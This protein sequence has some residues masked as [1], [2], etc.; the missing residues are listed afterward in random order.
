MNSDKTVYL[1]DY[2]KPDYLIPN[3]E[4]DF[5]ILSDRVL[6]SNT[7]TVIKNHSGN[8]PVKLNGVNL[9]LEK[10]ELDG[11]VLTLDQYS[12]EDDLL[13]IFTGLDRFILH[14]V[15]SINPFNNLSLEGFY[16]SGN[17]LCTQ[18]EPE[19]FR[20]I[21]YFIDRPDVMS[22]YKTKIT[23]DK[24]NFP[25]LL[26]NGNKISSGDLS[27][28]RHFVQWED[29]FPK[30]SYLFALV[31]GDLDVAED[32]FTTMSGRKISLSIFVDKGKLDRVG[33]A[34]ESLKKA[35]KW[36]EDRFGLECDLDNYMIVSVDSFNAGAMENKGL[37]IFN[38]KYTLGNP[39]TATDSALRGIEAVIAHEYF[40]NWTG[41]RITCRDWFQLT[42]KEGLTVF[43]DHEFSADMINEAVYRIGSVR[44]LRAAQ[45]PEDS[46]PLAHPIRPASYIE[47][48]NF[49]TSTVYEKGQEVIRMIQTFIGKDMF[50]KGID[51]YF[52]L[53][54]GQAVTTDEFINA[55]EI[56]SGRDFTQFRNWYSQEG[57][58]VCMASSL[59]DKEKK[60]YKL[61]ICQ[62]KAPN[63]KDIQ[64]PFCFPFILALLD[65]DGNPFSLSV[66]NETEVTLDIHKPS[67]TFIFD[68]INEKPVPSLLRNFSAPVILNYD[69]SIE[70]LIFLFKY[71]NDSFNRYEAGQRIAYYALESLMDSIIKK[72]KLNVA[73]DVLDAY[74]SVLI[75]EKLNPELRSMMMTLP[76]LSSTLEKMSTYNVDLAFAAREFLLK[77]L[78]LKTEKNLLSIY[79]KFAI[80]KYSSENKYIARRCLKNTC[81]SILSV[82][83]GRY[84][85]YAYKQYTVSKNMTDIVTALN[86]LNNS[87]DLKLRESVLDDFYKKWNTDPVVIN[88]WFTI[89]A[90]TKSGNILK[91][92]DDLSK[93][94][95]FDIKN[96]NKVMSLYGGFTANLKNF[97]DISGNGYKLL[98]DKIIEID[99]FNPHLAA[100]LAKSFKKY[101]E[102]DDK[103]KELM[104]LQLLRITTTNSC[105]KGLSEI[106][107]MI[108]KSN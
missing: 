43:R 72:E 74:E 6:V 8:N 5:N 56:A 17:I 26:S 60:Q 61:T 50:N 23:A 59:Y 16:K 79:K 67:E 39:E 38:S 2:C 95:I 102:L 19:G 7:M 53:Y 100:G 101:S 105:S 106:T 92:V 91:I 71:D 75:D 88:T 35:M 37:N 45:F 107:N 54:D 13:I 46:G 94:I 36:D 20:K 63:I 85:D 93:N 62:K 25:L 33:H 30:P 70:E 68:N 89:Q 104:N 41:N 15:T 9:Q 42:L 57:T 21:T 44:C 69:Y 108:L 31:V 90:L 77:K 55:M 65:K 81:L 96:P 32:S 76:S 64:K 66:S 22:R 58:P 87:H 27:N 84:I 48:D 78:A 83:E 86:C 10:V 24:T 97:H 40:H 51:K 11:I 3:I 1:K 82:L 99:K 49:Y 29:P 14:I 73:D 103:R 18:N 52:E 47:I 80:D 98:V 34:M 12:V 4:F 28:N